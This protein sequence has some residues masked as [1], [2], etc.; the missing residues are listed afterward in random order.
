MRTQLVHKTLLWAERRTIVLIQAQGGGVP[1]ERRRVYRGRP[2]ETPDDVQ[3]QAPESTP[4]PNNCSAVPIPTLP[5][6][7]ITQQLGIQLV[8]IT[9]GL[10]GPRPVPEQLYGSPSP[11]PGMSPSAV[12]E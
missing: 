10:G 12:G 9:P 3:I 2:R 5:L 4:N 6:V 11:D 7:H 1:P 8:H